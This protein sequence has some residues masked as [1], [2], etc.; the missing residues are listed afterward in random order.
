MNKIELL[1]QYKLDENININDF[2]LIMSKNKMILKWNT[3]IS[4]IYAWI[5]KVNNKMYIGRA[6]NLY[7]RVYS[8]KRSFKNGKHENLKKLFNA[9]KKYGVDIFDVKEL[10]SVTNKNDL[11]ELE[12]YFISYF[13][14]K[15]NGYNCTYGGDG[16]VGHIVTTEQREKQKKKMKEYWTDERKKQHSEKMKLWG[17]DDSRKSHLIFIGKQWINNP[18]LIE[19]HKNA[20]KKSM[21][22]ER[23]EKQKSSINKYYELNGGK[24]P[25]YKNITLFSPTNERVVVSKISSFCK[26]NNIGRMGFYR[27]LRNSQPQDCF[28][29]W[30]F[31]SKEI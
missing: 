14:T 23:I 8:E 26:T 13:N 7:R 21:S 20:C 9:V 1:K 4:G 6:N 19:K 3:K 11:I 25:R 31:I 5:N 18:I 15:D 24:Q 30:K 2:P 16:T 27:F 29:G 10:I 22:K 17:N 28:Q 12:K